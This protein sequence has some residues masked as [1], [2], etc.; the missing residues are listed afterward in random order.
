MRPLKLEPSQYPDPELLRLQSVPPATFHGEILAT[1]HYRPRFCVKVK[2]K[3]ASATSCQKALPTEPQKFS[4]GIFK[5]HVRSFGDLQETG[6]QRATQELNDSGSS[7]SRLLTNRFSTLDEAVNFVVAVGRETDDSLQSANNSQLQTSLEDLNH[8]QLARLETQLNRT[9]EP[10]H[11]RIFRRNVLLGQFT[12]GLDD[13][14]VARIQ[15]A[16]TLAAS[17]QF[18]PPGAINDSRVTNI[19]SLPESIGFGLVSMA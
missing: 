13:F 1:T 10:N 2:Q 5:S 8:R 6:P 7:L 4:H 17:L 11:P 3:K 14:T 15:E 18:L 12:A 19:A 16:V 9:L